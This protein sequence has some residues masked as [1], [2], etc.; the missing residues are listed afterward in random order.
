MRRRSMYTGE[1]IPDLSLKLPNFTA[2][3]SWSWRISA[4]MAD[5]SPAFGIGFNGFERGDLETT[6]HWRVW[7][8][9]YFRFSFILGFYVFF[10]FLKLSLFFFFW[11]KNYL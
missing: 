8:F 3:I 1:K 9:I 10:F 6:A 2:P 5:I 11:A 7:A 4:S